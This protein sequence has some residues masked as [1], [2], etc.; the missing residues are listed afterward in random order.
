MV[1]S[2]SNFNKIILDLLMIYSYEYKMKVFFLLSFLIKN[3]W[4]VLLRG[5]F[6]LG[7]IEFH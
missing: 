3:T 7:Q 5:T 2:A 4:S 1:N 6:D